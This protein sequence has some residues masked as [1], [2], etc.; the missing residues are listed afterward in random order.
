MKLQERE[1]HVYYRA[2]V[3]RSRVFENGLR[4]QKQQAAELFNRYRVLYSQRDALELTFRTDLQ[5]ARQVINDQRIELSTYKERQA[6]RSPDYEPSNLDL[7]MDAGLQYHAKSI[8]PIP[9]E[10]QPCASAYGARSVQITTTYEPAPVSAGVEYPVSAV[11][12]DL[13][14]SLEGGDGAGSKNETG[15]NKRKRVL[16]A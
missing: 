2:E 15:G 1:S 11:R 9:P 6:H 10:Q 4:M 7:A 3:E 5:K 8:S 12:D 13:D 14:Y 16:R